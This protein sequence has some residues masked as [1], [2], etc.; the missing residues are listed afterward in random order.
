MFLIPTNNQDE[1]EQH[2]DM[3]VHAIGTMTIWQLRLWHEHIL[4]AIEKWPESATLI[5]ASGA[6]RQEIAYYNANRAP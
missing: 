5:N 3:L 6:F 1:C 4:E 2:V